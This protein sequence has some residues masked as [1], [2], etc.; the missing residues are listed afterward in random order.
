MKQ[1]KKFCAG[2]LLLATL[3]SVTACGTGNN[4]VDNG[5]TGTDQNTVDDTD[6]TGDNT[7]DNGVNVDDI[8]F[9]TDGDG[10]YD[11]TDV[12]GDGLL[13]EIGQDANDVVDDLVNDVTGEGDTLVDGTE[14][15][16]N[17]GE[18]VEQENGADMP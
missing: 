15:T 16:V 18:T 4:N 2:L 17:N 8:L 9:D 12:D 6:T 1:W 10:V 7:T 3:V 11:H 5:T 14:D 13:E